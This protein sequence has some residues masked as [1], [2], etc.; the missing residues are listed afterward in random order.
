MY[1]YAITSSALSAYLIFAISCLLIWRRCVLHFY[2]FPALL[3]LA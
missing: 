3:L 2:A 1:Q